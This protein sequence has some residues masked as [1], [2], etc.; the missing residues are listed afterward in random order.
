VNVI[1]LKKERIAFDEMNSTAF[2]QLA[3]CQ[4]L[5]L[6]E[7]KLFTRHF[8]NNQLVVSQVTDWSTR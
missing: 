4:V 2:I 6:T 1:F 5:D 3:N 8:D 7:G